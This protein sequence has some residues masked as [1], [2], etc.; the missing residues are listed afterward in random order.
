MRKAGT[1]ID[2]SPRTVLDACADVMP[3]PSLSARLA[4][5]GTLGLDAGHQVVPGFDERRGPL[6]LEPDGKRVDVDTRLGEAGQNRLAVTSVRCEHVA[7][8]AVVAEGLEGALRHGVDR[9]RRGERL[10]VEDVAGFLVLG[11]GAGPEQALGPGAG[12]GSTLEAPRS[13]QFAIGLVAALSDRDAEPIAQL[14]RDLSSD[15]DVP[16]ADKER[17]DGADGRVQSRLDAPL[18]AAEVGFGGCDI[19]LPR[20]EQCD[21]DRN[22]G[23][24]RRLDGGQSFR[25]AGNFDE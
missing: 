18:D 21:I 6:V 11:A 7:D 4:D 22:T 17:G 13:E 3:L 1:L 16:A 9:E 8:L 10:H 20:E 23:E 19:L 2:W 15:R 25:S 12:I 24:D 14:V 5:G